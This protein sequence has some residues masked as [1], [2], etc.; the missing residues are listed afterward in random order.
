MTIRLGIRRKR[1][2]V[3][4]PVWPVKRDL[5]AVILAIDSARTSGHACYVAGQLASYG[6]LDA[7]VAARRMRVVNRALEFGRM[8]GM[9]AALVIE[10]PFGGSVRTAIS[11][12]AT[13][14]LW[15]DTWRQAGGAPGAIL[16]RQAGQW[17][18]VLFGAGSSRLKRDQLRQL[19]LACATEIVR[20]RFDQ[21]APPGP[22]ASAA[23]CIGRAMARS[24]E[25]QQT[26]M[27]R[28]VP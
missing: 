5:R 6:E 26:L 25:L 24:G 4:G 13:A 28:S 10:V 9:P 1:S 19:E 20:K 2:R 14:E 27:C 3:R 11:L 17:R 22:D 15:R 18:R 7:R 21:A 16:E 8:Y 12:A 23:I